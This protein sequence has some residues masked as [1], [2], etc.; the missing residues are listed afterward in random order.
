MKKGVENKK[1]ETKREYFLLR[2]GGAA[3][4]ADQPPRRYLGWGQKLRF[5]A[6][7]SS[8][9]PETSIKRKNIERGQSVL[10]RERG[11]EREICVEMNERWPYSLYKGPPKS[12][13]R[14]CMVLPCAPAS[15][16][17]DQDLV[18]PVVSFLDMNRA[19]LSKSKGTKSI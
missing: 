16:A 6:A 3:T 11:E 2:R 7:C 8:S 13:A 5:T 12:N 10:E 1:F 18:A 9:S 4:L 17:F 19:L 14:G 15:Q